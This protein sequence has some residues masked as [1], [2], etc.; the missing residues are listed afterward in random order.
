M[1]TSSSHAL[2]TRTC[3]G[4]RGV[5]HPDELL[6]IALRDRTA[7][8]DPHR[9]AGGRGAWVHP[10]SECVKLALQKRALSRAFR[11]E[12]ND[13]SVQAWLLTLQV[14]DEP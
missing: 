9:V 2:S 11:G 1:S 7:F 3:I 14:G 5:A 6:R 12:V 13:E 10:T 8:L 4:C